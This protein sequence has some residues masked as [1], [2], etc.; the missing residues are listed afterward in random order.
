VVV[1]ITVALVFL[2]VMWGRLRTMACA[3]AAMSLT[4]LFVF[5]MVNEGTFYL[6]NI[7]AFVVT[8]GVCEW[9]TQGYLLAPSSSDSTSLI[10]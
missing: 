8:L 7:V 2:R 5:S 10:A 4:A 3:P 1:L 9:L 6:Q